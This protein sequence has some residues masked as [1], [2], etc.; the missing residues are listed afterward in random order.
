MSRPPIR[1]R[2]LAAF[3]AALFSHALLASQA[4]AEPPASPAGVPGPAAGAGNALRPPGAIS[5]AEREAQ[6]RVAEERRIAEERRRAQ[7]AA[8]PPRPNPYRLTP[9]ERRRLR[10]QIREAHEHA[11]HQR[12]QR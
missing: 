1:L 2:R 9:E 10:D 3:C 11:R 12:G 7:A 6:R 8:P 4:M 5:P